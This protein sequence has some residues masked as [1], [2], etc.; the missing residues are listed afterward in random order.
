MLLPLGKAA[1]N[2][3]MIFIVN[4]T[5]GAPILIMFSTTRTLVNFIHSI[6]SLLSSAIYPEI[7]CAYG[8]KEK[9]TIENIYYR[10]FVV[11]IF[12]VS[13][14]T[15]LLLFAGKY[16]YLIWTNHTIMFDGFF[17]NG[18][19][20]VLFVSCLWN[21][22]SVILM[23]TNKHSSFTFAFLVVQLAGTTL[24]YIGL[25][26]YPHLFLI[27]IFLFITEF[28]LLLIALRQ[29]NLFLG[30]NFNDIR[31]GLLIGMKFIIKKIK[32]IYEKN[33]NSNIVSRKG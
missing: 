25:S 19:L 1:A 7:S 17:F 5:L 10:S 33:W 14:I 24:S 32:I 6:S 27:P 4:T 15:G 9:K 23:S 11:T 29:V 26:I 13:L 3:G 12:T 18:M 31:S 20:A 21:L 28:V 30:N 16:I 22:S 8:R 2:Q